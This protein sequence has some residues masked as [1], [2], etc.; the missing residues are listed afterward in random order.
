MNYEHLK[1]WE[2]PKNYFGATWEG[3]YVVLGH[4]RD[5]DLLTESNWSQFRDRLLPLQEELPNDEGQSVRVIRENHWAVGWVEW[6]GVHQSNTE[7]LALAESLREKL[8]SYP[9][10]NEEHWSALE[11]KAYD[12]SWEQYGCEDFR[13]GLLAELGELH[14]AQ[15]EDIEGRDSD[16]LRTLYESLIPSGEYFTAD[17]QGVSLCIDRAVNDCQFDNVFPVQS[18]KKD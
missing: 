1:L 9:V 10:L 7:A 13:K 5:S 17:G 16:S 11:E 8:E 4:N 2:H 18:S 3:W 12:E 14:A 15:I 6:L